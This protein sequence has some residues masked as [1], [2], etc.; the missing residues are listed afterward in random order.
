LLHKAYGFICSIKR[1]VLIRFYYTVTGLIPQTID[2]VDSAFH[3][4]VCQKSDFQGN[5]DIQNSQKLDPLEIT[6][7]KFRPKH[8]SLSKIFWCKKFTHGD[9]LMLFGLFDSAHTF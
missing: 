3:G 5:S 9:I 6:A 4:V 8:A 1:P 7:K 2:N